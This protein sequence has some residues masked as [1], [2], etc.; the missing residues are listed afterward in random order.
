MF[1]EQGIYNIHILIK[2][3]VSLL[4]TQLC[5]Y[6]VPASESKVSH[7]SCNLPNLLVHL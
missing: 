7:H 4:L 5:N 3:H 2:A 1:I 6:N